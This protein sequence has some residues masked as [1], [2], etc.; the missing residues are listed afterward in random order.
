MKVRHFYTENSGRILIT[1]W[2]SKPDVI[3]LY[4]S[5]ATVDHIYFVMQR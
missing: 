4:I 1:D 2:D 3:V 5:Y